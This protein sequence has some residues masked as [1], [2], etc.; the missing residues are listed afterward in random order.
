MGRP[1]VETPPATREAAVADYAHGVKL[2]VTAEKY[3][4]TIATI[5]IWARAAGLP[6]RPCG[7]QK[8]STPSDRDRAIIRRAREVA[9]NQVAKEYH[10]T[11]AGVWSIR[12]K[13]RL[14]KWVEPLPWK[15]GDTVEWA[16]TPLK[17]LRIYDEKRGAVCTLRGKVID[18]FRWKLNGTSLRALRAGLS[19]SR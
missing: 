15:V 3:G 14:A 2:R 16:G 13:W 9:I 18:P 19:G 12:N 5:S 11:R 1:I 8:T 7:I 6:R 10:M 4:F 17:V